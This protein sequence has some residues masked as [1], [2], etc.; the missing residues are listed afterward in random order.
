MNERLTIRAL[1]KERICCFAAEL[2]QDGDCI[3][4]DGGSTVFYLLSYLHN[5]KIKI[6]T[7]NQLIISKIDEDFLPEVIFIGGQYLS[8]YNMTVGAKSLE[9]LVKYNFDHAF[10]GCTGFSFVNDC[11]YTAEIDTLAIKEVVIQKS[12]HT[13]LLA[14]ASKYNMRGFC[15]MSNI[16]QFDTI[17]TNHNE[18][19]K[20]EELPD[21]IKLIT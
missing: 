16:Q 6:V 18:V 11:I 20:G 8:K 12:L 1:E 4:L 9:E 7:N 14:D 21:N 13:H 17:I 19:Y 10:I 3:Y 15:S 2:I 5:K